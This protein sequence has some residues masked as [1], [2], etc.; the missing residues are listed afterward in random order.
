MPE[1]AVTMTSC[2]PWPPRVAFC[3]RPSG[4]ERTSPRHVDGGEKE[5]RG[6]AGANCGESA[7]MARTWARVVR[8]CAH[9]DRSRST[10]TA[11]RWAMRRDEAGWRLTQ[12]DEVVLQRSDGREAASLECFADIPIRLSTQLRLAGVRSA[13][14]V[15]AR[16]VSCPP[17]PTRQLRSLRCGYRAGCR[18]RRKAPPRGTERSPG[19]RSVRRAG[20]CWTSPLR[21]RGRVDSP[22]S[23]HPRATRPPRYERKVTVLFGC[24]LSTTPDV[25]EPVVGATIAVGVVGVVEENEV[26][27]DRAGR[28]VDRAHC[29]HF[30]PGGRNAVSADL[31]VVRCVDGF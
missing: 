20:W 14:R 19:R 22:G 24:T 30:A 18:N 10:F 29:L 6:W 12:V 26:T 16:R 17:E 25:S 1:T 4:R 3:R 27:D 11:E 21:F 7:L 2:T 8:T 13:R 15:S 9:D 5:F 31:H 28:V 23:S